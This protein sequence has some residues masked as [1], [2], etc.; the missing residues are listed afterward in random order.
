[1]HLPPFDEVSFQ[2]DFSEPPESRVIYADVKLFMMLYH[3]LCLFYGLTG[4][5]PK[6]RRDRSMITLKKNHTVTSQ[7][8]TTQ[9]RIA[10]EMCHG[11]QKEGC[12]SLH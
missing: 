12:T 11:Q 10:T 2:T 7:I 5:R 4:N 9:E 8:K 6:S 1:M 3:L